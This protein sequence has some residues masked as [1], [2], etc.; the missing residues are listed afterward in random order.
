MKPHPRIRKTVKWGGPILCVAIV[1]L[2]VASASM[3]LAYWHSSSGIEVYANS[4][5]IAAGVWLPVESPGWSV[6]RERYAIQWWRFE[7]HVYSLEMWA[8]AFPIWLPLPL[9]LSATLGA[10]RLDTLARRRARSGKC[11]KCGYDRRGLPPSSPCPEC[12]SGPGGKAAS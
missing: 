11:P 1:V 10:W 4:G 3:R 5:F 12:G 7:W 6:D 9:V 2:F 8:I